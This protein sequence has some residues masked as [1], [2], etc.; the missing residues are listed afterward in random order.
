M[1]PFVFLEGTALALVGLPD[2]CPLGLEASPQTF[3]ALVMRTSYVGLE[4]QQR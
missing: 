4:L 3:P 1:L 2:G